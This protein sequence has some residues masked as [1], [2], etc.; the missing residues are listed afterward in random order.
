MSSTS[1][2]RP[3]VAYRSRVV[4]LAILKRRRI[5]RAMR[6]C[7]FTS[8][9]NTRLAHVESGTD[10]HPF[11]VVPMPRWSKKP[12]SCVRISSTMSRSNTSSIRAAHLAMAAAMAA[13]AEVVTVAVTEAE[14]TT[15]AV[16][17][18]VA[19]GVA[20]TEATAVVATTHTTDTALTMP[21]QRPTVRLQQA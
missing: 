3:D 1:N 6:T 15:I 19:T 4:A 2:T 8:R 16:E 12:R 10:F 17:M 18:M 21:E 9:K 7:S 14:M 5:K 13:T 20:M 11:L